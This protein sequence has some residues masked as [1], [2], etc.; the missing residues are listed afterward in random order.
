MINNKVLGLVVAV[1]FILSLISYRADVQ[2]AERFERG[3]RFLANLNQDEIADILITKHDQTTH[4]RRGTD[5]FTVV[6][7][8][9]YPAE[10]ASVGRFV[11]SILEIGL[12]KEIGSGPDL[13]QELG[14]AAGDPAATEIVLKDATDKV[15]VQFLIGNSHEDGSGNYIRRT[16]AENEKIY[17]TSASPQIG[18]TAMDYLQTEILNVPADQVS[19]IRGRDY[20]L[21]F[22]DDQLSASKQSGLRAVLSN[23]RFTE[24]YLA[25]APQVAGLR[26][27]HA[28]VFDLLDDSGYRFSIASHDDTDYLRIEAF[29]NTQQIT[30]AQDATEEEAGEKAALL[31]RVNE[32]QTFNDFHGSWIYVI[33]DTKRDNLRLRKQDLL[34]DKE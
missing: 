1:L 27:T 33:S 3:Q 25:D 16:D 21:E 31:E 11:T 9:G 15:M 7:A 18:S 32:V 14:V 2:R 34:E 30:I 4:L 6:T 29:H 8:D 5:Q 23:L 19:A 22:Q 20:V 10:N 28:V 12:E 24:H 26:F 17:L 13:E